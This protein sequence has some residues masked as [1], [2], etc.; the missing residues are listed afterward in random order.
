[1]LAVCSHR[2][3]SCIVTQK[4][5]AA[6]LLAIMPSSKWRLICGESLELFLRLA[7]SAIVFLQRIDLRWASFELHMIVPWQGMLLVGMKGLG[8]QTFSQWILQDF[9]CWQSASAQC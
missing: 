9:T 3:N 1:V 7:D 8:C 2:V 4:K 5:I 6:Q